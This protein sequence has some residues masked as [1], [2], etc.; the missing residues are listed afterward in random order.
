MA[1]EVQISDW[2]HLCLFLACCSSVRWHHRL[3]VS[4]V[5]RCI[6]HRRS[7]SALYL[8]PMRL[9][10]CELSAKSDAR[11]TGFD[12]SVWGFRS[13]HTKDQKIWVSDAQNDLYYQDCLRAAKYDFCYILV[14][15]GAA[16][17]GLVAWGALFQI[18]LIF[19]VLSIA[20][21]GT[22]SEWQEW[23]PKIAGLSFITLSC[24]VLIWG[25][26]DHIALQAIWRPDYQ[27]KVGWSLIFAAI[28]AGVSFVVMQYFRCAIQ[29]RALKD[30]GQFRTAAVASWDIAMK[31]AAASI[32][33]PAYPASSHMQQNWTAEPDSPMDNFARGQQ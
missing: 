22:S 8:R 29:Y 14:V 11:S 10:L 19:K 7:S 16:S 23:M 20:I 9:L 18:I 28:S 27:A 31:E 32:P 24:G 6:R 5:Y 17:M 13:A 4:C 15:G 12:S 25:T 2:L 3:L 30:E 26:S 21:C 33:M 1:R